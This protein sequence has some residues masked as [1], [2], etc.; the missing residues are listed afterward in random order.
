MTHS[1]IRILMMLECLNIGG[2]ETHTL[3]LTKQLIQCGID[4]TIYSFSGGNIHE[5]FTSLGCPVYIG[6][7][8]AANRLEEVHKIILKHRINIIHTH[9]KSAELADH[10]ASKLH[11]PL[12]YTVHGTYYDIFSKLHHKNT[13]FVSV[14]SPIKNWLDAKGIPSTLIHNGIDMKK[15]HCNRDQHSL[16]FQLGIPVDTPLIVYAARLGNRKKFKLCDAFI[17]TC[18]AIREKFLSNMHVAI[19]GG[20]PNNKRRF[21][22][23]KD[24]VN[25]IN[26]QNGENF[27]H[28]LGERKDM[29]RIYR[30][31]DCVVGTGRIALEAMACETKVI[32]VGSA[33]YVGF[34]TPNNFHE[35]CLL[36]FGDHA[37]KAVF[38]KEVFCKDIA[39]VFLSDSS[40]DITNI[41]KNRE[42]VENKFSIERVTNDLLQVYKQHMNPDILR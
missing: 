26:K 37:G 18:P 6:S 5:D 39:E 28:V 16:K 30:G 21:N 11:L 38:S 32:A 27:I 34:I 3:S 22:L 40:S 15:Y 29:E 12:I 33:G 14:S 31:S 20:S 13:A 7:L 4:V 41:K 9:D 35:A 19:V 24:E 2:T 8:K 42:L 36:H 23:I 17:K 10:A 1:Q 25:K